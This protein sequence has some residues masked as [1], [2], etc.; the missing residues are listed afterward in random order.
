EYLLQ[1]WG[2]DRRIERGTGL[3]PQRLDELLKAFV[4]ILDA[5]DIHDAEID[6]RLGGDR[7]A[8]EPAL[9]DQIER[10]GQR[11]FGRLELEHVVIAHRTLVE[12]LD[13]RGG[14]GVLRVRVAARAG[15]GEHDEGGD[16]TEPR[17]RGHGRD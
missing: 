11:L 9:L 12:L 16:H 3:D 7:I 4:S 15:E 8:V 10:I 2:A 1:L 5:R 13:L 17:R 14:G 6:V